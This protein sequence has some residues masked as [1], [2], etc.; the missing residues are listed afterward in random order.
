MVCFFSPN[1][2]QMMTFLNPHDALIPKIPFSFFVDFWVQVISAARGSVSVGFGGFRQ[3]SPFWGGRSSQ[4]AL[5]NPPSLPTESPPALVLTD[6]LIRIGAWSERSAVGRVTVLW[7]VTGPWGPWA[8]GP[9]PCQSQW[10]GLQPC[11]L[12]RLPS[13]TGTK[14]CGQALKACPWVAC[15]AGRRPRSAPQTRAAG[16]M[17]SATSHGGVTVASEAERQSKAHD[18][19]NSSFQ[20]TPSSETSLIAERHCAFIPKVGVRATSG[21]VLRG[22]QGG[23][24][25]IPLLWRAVGSGVGGP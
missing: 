3:L 11:A 10:W 1:I 8:I 9:G 7:A 16:T 24:P 19:I 5:S 12:E 13:P 17:D 21:A 25:W 18:P 15:R 4:G 14:C 22:I 2:W 20:W 23:C 6:R